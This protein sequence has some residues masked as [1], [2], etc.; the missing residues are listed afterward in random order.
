MVSVFLETRN[1]MEQ[2]AWFQPPESVS[3][4]DEGE[5]GFKTTPCSGWQH[6][7]SKIMSKLWFSFSYN[8]YLPPKK[9]RWV[10]TKDMPSQS[11]PNTQHCGA[12]RGG[13]SGDKSDICRSTVWASKSDHQLRRLNTRPTLGT[14]ILPTNSSLISQRLSHFSYLLKYILNKKKGRNCFC[15]FIYSV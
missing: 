8:N 9:T 14:N 1:Y 11:L 12:A 6:S 4:I 3:L 13:G 2:T 10:K 5:G 7:T 15:C